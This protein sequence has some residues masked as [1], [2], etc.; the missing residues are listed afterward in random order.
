MYISQRSYDSGDSFS[1]LKHHY[2]FEKLGPKNAC[3]DLES[4]SSLIIH[5]VQNN[6]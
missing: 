1:V 4:F 3:T 2:L 5:L 6:V